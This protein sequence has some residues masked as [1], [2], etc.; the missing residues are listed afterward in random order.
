MLTKAASLVPGHFLSCERLKVQQHPSQPS[1]DTCIKLITETLGGGRLIF[2]GIHFDL[3]PFSVQ[4]ITHLRHHQQLLSLST[5]FLNTLRQYSL[6]NGQGNWQTGLTF[7]T[8]F[9]Q[10][11]VIKS[12]L[13]LDGEMIHQ[14]HHRCLNTPQ[15]AV[16]T[17][18]AHHWLIEQMLSQL[19]WQPS[20][21]LLRISWLLAGLLIIIS[22]F[23]L[24]PILWLFTLP[25]WWL[26]QRGM[27]TLLRFTL[28]PWIWRQLLKGKAS[29]QN[30]AWRLL[31]LLKLI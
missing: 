27:Q 24:P 29:R 26:L 21:L 19:S 25:F 12:Y 6:N 14:I 17:I 13:A 18:Q 9:Q 7:C 11:P 16:E 2:H 31:R 23:L 20:H 5:P 1:L 10:Q 15:L 8:Y 28:R 4:A 30:L 3:D 22:L